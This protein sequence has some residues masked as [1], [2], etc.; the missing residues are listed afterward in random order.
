MEGEVITNRRWKKEATADEIWT[1]T[2]DG[3][4]GR[5]ANKQVRTKGERAVGRSYMMVAVVCCML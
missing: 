5:Q 3:I 1:I 2:T 4:S